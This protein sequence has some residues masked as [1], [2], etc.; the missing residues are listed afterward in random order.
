MSFSVASMRGVVEDFPR[1]PLFIPLQLYQPDNDASHSGRNFDPLRAR[2]RENIA[3]LAQIAPAS[4]PIVASQINILRPPTITKRTWVRMR[5]RADQIEDA[6]RRPAPIDQ[7]VGGRAAAE[8][9]AGGQILRDAGRASAD[10]QGM[11][12]GNQSGRRAGSVY[13]TGSA[14]YRGLR[15]RRSPGRRCR[16]RRPAPPYD[17]GS[18]RFRARR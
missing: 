5:H 4:A 6:P 15:S 18:R 16:R 10:D 3:G 12:A 7:A 9:A 17:A 11:E 14:R 8:I 13:D 2:T 1:R